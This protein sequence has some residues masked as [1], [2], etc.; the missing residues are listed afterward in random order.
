MENRAYAIAVGI[1]TLTLGVCVALAYWWFSGSQQALTAYTISSQLPVSGLSPEAKVKFRGVDIGKVTEISLDPA[2]QTTILI[3]IAVSQNLKLSSGAYAELHLQGLTGLAFID[4]NDESKN[5]PSLPAGG[6]IP[7]RSTMMDKLLSQAPQLASQLEVLLQ[8]GS[9]LTTSA[10][11]VLASLDDQKLKQTIANL[12]KAS[13]KALPA[14]ES[15]T[16]MF[17]S[18]NSMASKQNQTR[19]VQTME[20]IQ[21]TS[22]AARPLISELALT[23]EKFRGTAQQIESSSSQLAQTLDN[24]TLP[25]LHTLTQNMNQS[26]MH[27][28]Q[29]IDVMEEN[30]QSFI[31]GKPAPSP[32]PGEAGFSVKP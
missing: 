26:V 9:Q 1:F 17:N 2:S 3:D 6:T 14:L 8:N 21:Q 18:I 20:S 15:A 28:N 12:E 4:L 29:L 23:A 5:A 19:L 22:D 11:R 24:E 7:L 25:Q 10:N 16:K 13:E 30:P 27:F 32:G 31:F